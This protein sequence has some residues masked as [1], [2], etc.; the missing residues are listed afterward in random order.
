V[1]ARELA[2]VLEQARGSEAPILALATSPYCPP[3][4]RLK[5]RL[6]TD[7]ELQ[8]L[9]E[10]Y[11]AVH[12]DT[13]DPA[14]AEWSRKY[15]PRS[16]MVPMLFIVSSSGQVLYN[17]SGAPSGPRL[18]ELLRR[19][20]TENS[21]LAEAKKVAADQRRQLT[22]NHAGTLIE[23]RKYAEA[24]RALRPLWGRQGEVQPRDDDGGQ[25]TLAKLISRLQKLGQSDLARAQQYLA[26]EQNRLFGLLALTK[27]RRVFRDLPEI[28]GQADELLDRVQQD[29]RLAGRLGQAE[30]IDRGRAAEQ[31]GDHAAAVEI[32]RQAVAT[33]RGSLAERLC[34][35]RIKQLASENV[36]SRLESDGE[37]A[38]TR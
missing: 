25:D 19:G 13:K 16:T 38:A 4:Q 12:F 1:D 34:T 15:P 21:R 7:D 29:P 20:L 11:V 22:M 36:A 37:P 8:S 14:F 28:S 17:A 35:V 18:P 30:L 32:Y 6:E 2:E 9:V 23:Q 27:A 10:Q 3:C 26:D 31:A 24:I 33:Y 5:T